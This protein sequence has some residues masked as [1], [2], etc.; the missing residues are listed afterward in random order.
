MICSFTFNGI[1]VPITDADYRFKT[2]DV[3]PG[4]GLDT[5]SLIRREPTTISVE[6]TIPIAGGWDAFAKLIRNDPPGASS[7]TLARRVGYGG[8]KGRSALRRLF[9]RALPV[10]MA[11]DRARFH[12]RAVMV[13]ETDMR[14]RLRGCRP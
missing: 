11:T 8:R 4:Y 7:R 6:A 13:S 10:A 3:E 12:G 9:A 2:S 1:S 14:I 5:F